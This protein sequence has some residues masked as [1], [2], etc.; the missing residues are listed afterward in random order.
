[1][2][3]ELCGDCAV[4]E[5]KKTPQF[6]EANRVAQKKVQ[7]KPEQRRKNSESVKK[8][9]A[10]NPDKKEIMRGKLLSKWQEP[11]FL[12][13]AQSKG[14][15]SSGRGTQGEY[16]RD[17]GDIVPF[18]S[19]Y[20]LGFLMWLDSVRP[21]TQVRRCE[22]PYIYTLSGKRRQFF[23]DF[24]FGSTNCPTI[25]EIKSEF[26]AKKRPDALIAKKEC[27]NGLVESGEINAFYYIDEKK[28]ES[29]GIDFLRRRRNSVLSILK[30][31]GRIRLKDEI[32]AQNI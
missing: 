5:I 15:C 12:K 17:C 10:N 29:L 30:A 14:G 31:E 3:A 9:W 7:S 21:D 24:E 11:E 27:M 26:I 6:A 8:F 18:D 1:M 4:S 20:E 13:A 28:A 19:T 25:V 16:T 23:P 2:T 32:K 22:N